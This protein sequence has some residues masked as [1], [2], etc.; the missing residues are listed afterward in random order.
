MKKIRIGITGTGSLIGQAIIKSVRAASSLSGRVSMTGFDYF[1]NTVGS[2]WV[3]SHF[4][5]P[6]LLKRS[7]STGQWL[8]SLMEAIEKDGIEVLFPGVDFELKPLAINRELIREKTG[9]EVMVSSPKVIRIADDKYLTY[10]FLKANSLAR[11]KTFLPD[12]TGSREIIFPCILKP[13]IG[14]RARDVFIIK[15]RKDLRRKL[16]QVNNPLIQELV[17]TPEAEYTCGAICL[18][19]D[20]MQLITLRRTLK[21]GNTDTVWLSKDNPAVVHDYVRRVAAALKPYGACNF[22]L[23]LGSDG[24]PRLFEINARHSGTTYMRALLGFNEVEYLLRRHMGMP[25]PAFDLRDGCVK[26]YS[27]EMIVG[28]QGA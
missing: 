8:S 19:G 10:K 2:H 5:L 3:Q 22:Q 11:P 7:V 20:P 14:A 6:D 13:R 1:A 4:L 24:Q 15:D 16:A 28:G 25:P 21:D 9:C 27:E 26:R 23:R 18:E 17:G 12:E